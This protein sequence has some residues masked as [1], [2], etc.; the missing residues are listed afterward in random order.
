MKYIIL[1][2]EKITIHNFN[3]RL[4]DFVRKNTK[5]LTEVTITPRLTQEG[6]LYITNR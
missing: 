4:L 6:K 1:K 2:N 5:G 3:G